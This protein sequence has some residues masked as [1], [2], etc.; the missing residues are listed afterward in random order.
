MVG[1][2]VVV[3]HA[4]ISALGLRALSVVFDNKIA[5]Y[6]LSIVFGAAKPAVEHKSARNKY[7]VENIVDSLI[8]VSPHFFYGLHIV[9]KVVK[10]VWLY[11][12]ESGER[13]ESFV[14]RAVE[15][16]VVKVANANNFGKRVDG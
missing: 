11:G 10:T 7:L 9:C 16:S 4:D 13:V 5:V 14:Y 1:E 8:I 6:G 12:V 3:F 15:R 2:S